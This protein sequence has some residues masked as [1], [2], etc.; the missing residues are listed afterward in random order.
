MKT[1]D[2]RSVGCLL[3]NEEGQILVFD[4]NTPP[5]GA[6]PPT[7]HVDDHGSLDEAVRA[8]VFEETGYQAGE[9]SL[10]CGGWTK[11]HCR[12]A[13]G[14]LGHG[15]RWAVYHCTD[16]TGQLAPSA[17]EIRN[18]RWVSQS[19]LQD[20]F[21]RTVEFGRGCIPDE[22]FAATPGL[23]PVWGYWMAKAGLITA[24]EE[25]IKLMETMFST[26]KHMD[27]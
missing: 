10:I 18:A 14:P 22:E 12:R 8:E 9:I 16:F 24:T 11:N 2:N 7:G 1:C 6:A 20:L 23:E 5:Q 19:K 3:M 4:R 17:R 27:T 26:V 25:Q 15:H 21:D 13:A